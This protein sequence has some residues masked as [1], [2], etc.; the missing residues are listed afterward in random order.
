MK[1]KFSE[2]SPKT[3]KLIKAGWWLIGAV[4]VLVIFSK[5]VGDDPEE[6]Q[7]TGAP[8]TAVD[9]EA[10]V[11]AESSKL[12]D[13]LKNLIFSCYA[14]VNLLNE[15]E[16]GFMLWGDLFESEIFPKAGID[17]TEASVF[18]DAALQ[19]AAEAAGTTESL[20]ALQ[21]WKSVCKPTLFN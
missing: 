20:V 19:Q 21:L 8:A 18:G 5:V 4:W 6:L 11:F 9:Q 14:A 3:Q 15:Q 12:T 7:L 2:N 16:S 10:K 1:I 13:D 17:P